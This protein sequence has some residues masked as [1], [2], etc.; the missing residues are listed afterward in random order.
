MLSIMNRNFFPL[1]CALILV[2]CSTQCQNVATANQDANPAN[3]ETAP[4]SHAA[5]PVPYAALLLNSEEVKALQKAPTRLNFVLTKLAK[6]ADYQAVPVAVLGPDPHY[7][8]GGVNTK[9]D[10]GSKHLSADAVAAYNNALCYIAT[11]DEHY[12]A[13][14]Q[15]ILDAWAGT[16]KN[17]STLQGR[18]NIN[19]NFPSM[20]IAANWVKGANNWNNKPFD[21]FL[22]TT[23]LPQSESKTPNNHGLWGVLLESSAAAYLG[24]QRLLKTAR[25]R[26]EA[27]MQSAVTPNGEMPHEMQRSDTNNWIGGPTKGIKGMAYTHYAL[28]P[29]SLSAK[30][31]ADQG[32]PVWKTPGGK[33]L[34]AA[35]KR[36]AAWTR[37]PETF[38]YYAS[39]KGQLIGVRNA[40]YFALLRKF[41][42]D[43]NADAVLKEGKVSMNGFL[44]L[45]LFGQKS[46]N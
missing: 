41:Y 29:A 44:L 27:L 20:I 21:K 37:H 35:F 17:V 5:R 3:K 8:A 33:R 10:D 40:A 11:G 7:N 36:A 9:K 45:Q 38:P 14:T 42:P 28:L 6:N 1:L 24:D 23:I 39:N 18:A 31:F 43:K 2:G 15:G 19:F 22:R 34:E 30:I 12:A 13:T 32:Q 46:Q 25:N 26:W 16:L 4:T